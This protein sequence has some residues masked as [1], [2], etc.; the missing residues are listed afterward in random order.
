MSDRVRNLHERAIEEINSGRPAVG[1]RLL[2]DAL[3]LGDRKGPLTARLLGTLAAAE[4]AQGNTGRALEL[5]DEAEEVVAPEDRHLLLSQRALVFVLVGRMDDALS[6]F[7]DAILRLRRTDQRAAL[8]RVLLNRG[9][10]HQIAG[11]VRLA[12]A[13]L[14]QCAQLGASLGPD[15]GMPRTVAK[16]VHGRGQC[17]VLTGDIPGALRDF[18]IAAEVYADQ[19]RGMLAVLAGDR[20]RALLAAGLP[21]EAATELDTFLGRVPELRMG[22]EHAEAELTMARARLAAGD[23]AEARRWAALARRRFHRRRNDTWT[24]VAELAMLRADFAAGNVTVRGARSAARLADRLR[25]LGLRNDADEADLLAARTYLARGRLAEARAHLSGRDRPGAPLATRL[26]RRLVLAELG[27]AEGDQRRTF[28]EARAGLALLREHRSR[29]GSLDLQTG[30]TSL[31]GELARAGLAA[32]LDNGKPE[33]VYRWLERSRAQAF[34]FPPVRTPA[35]EHTVDAVAALR[36][37]AREA[38][39][40]ELKGNQ[41]SDALRRARQLEREIRAKGW[42]TDGAGERHVEVGFAEVKAELADADSVLV[43]FLTDEGRLLAQVVGDRRAELLGLGGTH[44]VFE[45]IARLRSDLD[46]ACG[47]RLPEALQQ[48]IHTSIRRQLAVLAEHLLDPLLRVIGDHNVVLVPTGALS[49]MPWSLL[50]AL[51]GR[52]V[53]VTPSPSAWVSAKRTV[54][55]PGPVLL[56][57]GP[58]LK[59]SSDEVRRI[60][61]IYEHSTVLDGE[62]ATVE[63]T[64]DAVKRSSLAHFA[65]HGHHEQENVLFSRLDLVDGP[66]MAHDV[67][68]LAAVPDHVVLSSCDIGQAVVR[69]GDEILGFTAALLYSGSRT[70]VSSV[71]RV[72]DQAAVDV[73]TAYHQALTRG[74][75]P[76]KALADATQT[77]QLMPF[78]CHGWGG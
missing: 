8:A 50:D 71:A 35:D 39:A 52:P 43:S 68:Q 53:T 12:L 36:Q 75:P 22:H 33:V 10:L 56:V 70:V 37:L 60:A 58:N 38:R 23:P 51:R 14:D 62:D 46:A 1:A 29:F 30:T 2:R 7:D 21:S 48:V 72:D 4:V 63:K 64:L 16:A 11:R 69:T 45:A 42:R 40:A 34:R 76:G 49:A 55:P 5:L 66:L 41:D 67:H 65:S 77:Q 19:G 32:A 9:M 31:G 6:L 61:R 78:V 54:R 18:D 57:G 3:R 25:L 47:R 27:A 24:A 74:V 17:R 28:A 26:L 73:M 15:E 20:A 59:H 44:T 13:D